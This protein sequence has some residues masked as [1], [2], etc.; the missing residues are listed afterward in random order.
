MTQYRQLQEA[1]LKPPRESVDC[2]ARP[3]LT[4]LAEVLYTVTKK[5]EKKNKEKKEKAEEI[6]T[7][8]VQQNYIIPTH[9]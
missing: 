9:D 4:D 7:Q 8:N 2:F 6:K 3:I 5:K 1:S